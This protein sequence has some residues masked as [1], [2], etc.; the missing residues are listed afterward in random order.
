MKYD[1]GNIVV[2]ES[3][4]TIYI[5]NYDKETKKYKGFHVDDPNPQE[6]IK[7]SEANIIMQL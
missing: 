3:E 1:I 4:E 7:F 2:L 5:T 6:E